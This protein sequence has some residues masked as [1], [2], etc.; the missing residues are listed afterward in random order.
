AIA[1][2]AIL[3]PT[4][5]QRITVKRGKGFWAE[6][7]GTRTYCLATYHR[8]A[9][10]RDP[11]LFRDMVADVQKFLHNEAPIPTPLP[12]VYVS[13]NKEQ[14]LRRLPLLFQASRLSCDIETTG[15][16]SVTDMVVSTGFGVKRV[17]DE[18]E[19]HIVPSY[20]MEDE[21]V[22]EIVRSLLISYEGK[23]I[24]HNGKF[25]LRM[26]SAFY[27]PTLYPNNFVDTLLMHATIDERSSSE[28]TFGRKRLPSRHG[29][30]ALSRLEF[31]TDYG[32]D[33]TAF[34]NIESKKKED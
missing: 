23:L 1:L 24:F 27:K 33:F 6:I 10:L 15:L 5:I 34:W 9:I 31:D 13:W 8:A 29:L 22:K 25:D 17:D 28:S 32:F 2:Q 19:C 12:H 26:L 30:K 11:E 18:I 14:A 3:S 7:N 16:S 20:V 4:K 21:E